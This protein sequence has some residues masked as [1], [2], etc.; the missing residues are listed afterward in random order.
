MFIHET[1]TIGDSLTAKPVGGVRSA[2]PTGAIG[3]VAS[4]STGANAEARGLAFDA[5][6][7]PRG[8]G[9]GT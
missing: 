6:H 1:V 3:K 7:R 2:E 5:W 8:L 9:A 4:P